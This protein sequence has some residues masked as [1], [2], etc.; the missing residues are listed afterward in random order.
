M[1]VHGTALDFNGSVILLR[2]D[3]GSGKSDLALRLLAAGATLIGDDYV[4]IAV[5]NK[6]LQVTA[7]PE[8]HGMLEVRGIG[9]VYVQQVASMDS[10]NELECIIDL[11]ARESV[12]RMPDKEEATE[13]ML[14]VNVKRLKLH[15]FDI[16]T[17]LKIALA[18]G[19][20]ITQL[21]GKV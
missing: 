12:T 19:K 1:L 5:K 14:G 3:S 20:D 21:G 11:V 2:G 16:S 8:L 15:A 7:A 13:V 9:I 4:T 17:P 18:C 6:R 10:A